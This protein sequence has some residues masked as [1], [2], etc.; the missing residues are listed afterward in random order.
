MPNGVSLQV[1]VGA[2]DLTAVVASLGA[3]RC[4]A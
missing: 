3:L 2:S 4:C 1:E